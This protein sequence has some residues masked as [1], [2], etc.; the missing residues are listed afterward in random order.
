MNRKLL[1]LPALLGAM[2]PVITGCGGSGG[3]SGGSGDPIVIGTTDSIVLTK[4]NP[5]PLDP[6]TSYDNATWNVFN[7]TFQELLGY[8][9][10]STTPTPD[11]AKECHYTDTSG[12][13]Y[14]CTMRDGLKFSNGHNLTADDVKFSVDR[15]QKINWPTGPAT[16]IADVK[17]V[18]APDDKTVVFH[19]K[20]PDAT[21]PAKL[22]TPAAA[23]VDSSVYDPAKPLDGFKLVGSGPYVLDSFVQG[24]QAEFS[25]NPHYQ[26]LDK[27]SN[28]KIELKLFNDSG[29][30][31]AA[32]KGGTIDVMSRT[33]A[34][35]QIT[36]LQNSTDPNLK[37][38]EAP[39][40]ETR[41]LFL[42]TASP[43]LKDRAVRQAIAEII[44]RQAITREIYKRTADPLYSVVPQGI[45]SHTNSFFNRYHNPSVS[46]AKK[47]L[48]D[49]GVEDKVS[50]T[51]NYRQDTGGT[52]NKP[53]A[54][55]IAKQL[56]ASGLFDVTTQSEEWSAFLK[57]ASQRKYEIFAVSWLP[58]FPD[59]D[60]YIAPF[61]DKDNFLNLAYKNTTIQD[62]I[63]PDTR[64]QS[65]RSTASSAFGQAQDMIAQD[66]PMLPLWQGKQ[67]IA[68]RSD[69]TGVE[70]ALNA[71]TATQFW[72]LGRGVSG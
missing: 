17:S 72:E 25:R 12:L 23:I 42:N 60:N 34:P 68:S 71:T 46:K 16:L 29:K 51:I 7:N 9:R 67:Y 52:V 56:N 48:K 58:D 49:A 31:E 32:L 8:T 43:D 65:E 38:T 45:T 19:L 35:D 26:G 3:G 37:L 21:F 66:V 10:G 28:D 18:N 13:T 57:A 40:G 6:A 59:P 14:Q 54:Q 4:D 62:Q 64:R 53:E 27:I 33:M 1:V 47:T 24:K 5:A 30:M 50:L 44:D 39:G 11:A 70:W 61:F 36:E 15:M 63:L 20:A 41:Y 69:I 2:T 22:A 55:A